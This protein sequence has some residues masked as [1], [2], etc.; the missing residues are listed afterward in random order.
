MNYL[1]LSQV[2]REL[3][4]GTVVL[5]LGGFNGANAE[6]APAPV[7]ADACVVSLSVAQSDTTVTVNRRFGG[8]S[9]RVTIG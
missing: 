9:V 7:S 8:G 2:R 4:A 3:L 1:H 5:A 6:P